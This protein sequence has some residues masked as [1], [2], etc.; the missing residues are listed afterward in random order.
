[1]LLPARFVTQPDQKPSLDNASECSGL[2][3]AD[4]R[5]SQFKEVTDR[6]LLVE[7]RADPD[8]RTIP[9]IVRMK[10]DLVGVRIHLADWCALD[11][12]D[13]EF[14]I[15][16][17]VNAPAA[18]AEYLDAL[19]GMLARRGRGQV[20]RIPPAKADDTDWLGEVEPVTV[21]A[22]RKRA[23]FPSEWSSMT[24][25]ERYLLCH[26]VRKNDPELCRVLPSELSGYKCQTKKTVI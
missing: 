1:M 4:N 3:S 11:K 26:A 6:V 19:S 25:F 22:F 24:R 2:G 9:L 8:G 20:E 18:I 10:L 21:V 14:L 13:C 7:Q 15:A 12:S 17:P 16:A 23:G 5:V